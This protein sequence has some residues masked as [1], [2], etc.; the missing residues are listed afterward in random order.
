MDKRQWERVRISRELLGLPE[1]ATVAEI[2]KAYRRLTKKHHPDL[3][4]Q[5]QEEFAD[6]ATEMPALTE[7][8]R[9]LLEYCKNYR[10]PLVPGP[11]QAMDDEEW[12]MDR[13]GEDPLWSPG[14]K[15]H[16]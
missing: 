8:C 11:G 13:F 14:R 6:G 1:E 7:A 12:W 9:V 15:R 3:A 2:K 10:I 4:G 16:K 5:R